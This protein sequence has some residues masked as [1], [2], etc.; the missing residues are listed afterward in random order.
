MGDSKK[1]TA[2][3]AMK[4][5]LDSDTRETELDGHRK[6]REDKEKQRKIEKDSTVYKKNID[7]LEVEYTVKNYPYGA[8]FTVRIE[9]QEYSIGWDR[10]N[11]P[12]K[13]LSIEKAMKQVP[14][15]KKQQ[16][17]SIFRA[18]ALN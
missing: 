5:L 16:Y 13:E 18:I 2:D 10:D 17:E 1:N 9:G 14:A 4:L 6:E 3:F 7:G 8:A 11:G 12:G 15:E